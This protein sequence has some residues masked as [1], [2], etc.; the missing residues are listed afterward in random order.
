[1]IFQ[2][3]HSR[4][5]YPGTGI[6]LAMT[7]KIVEYHGG[8]IWLDTESAPGHTTFR[9]ALPDKPAAEK[10]TA[11]K[12]PDTTAQPDETALSKPV[13]PEEPALSEKIE[14]S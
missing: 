8:R 13:R 7:R 2:R 3:L 6:G 1:V 5:A 12:E 11:G 9:F 10:D 4:D 14:E